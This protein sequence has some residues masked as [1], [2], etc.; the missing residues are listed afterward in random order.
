MDKIQTLPRTKL[1]RL[2]SSRNACSSLVGICQGYSHSGKQLSF[3]RNCQSLAL[4][5]GNRPNKSRLGL[6]QSL[7]SSVTQNR[8]QLGMAA[9]AFHRWPEAPGTRVGCISLRTAKKKHRAPEKTRRN[10]KCVY[11]K[12]ERATYCVIP[13]QDRPQGWTMETGKGPAV[14]PAGGLGDAQQRDLGTARLLSVPVMVGP[15]YH[16]E[17][18][19]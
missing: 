7:C 3:V 4:G 9:V 8:Q 16:A 19:L 13:P 12:S 10:W 5:F 17:N 6:H 14:A 11:V 2:W 1:R 18:K 15:R